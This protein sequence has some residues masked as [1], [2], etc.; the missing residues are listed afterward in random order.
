MAVPRLLLEILEDLIEDDF[1]E[2]KWLLENGV[3][4]KPIARSH[5]ENAKRRDTVRKMIDTYRE[6]MAV[7]IAVG[8]LKEMGNNN[9]AEK[10]K[11]SYAAGGNTATPSTSTSAAA[12]PAAPAAPASM[13][14]Q[15]GSI[16]IAPNVTGGTSGTWNININK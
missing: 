3:D 4:F 10:L 11:N 6:E 2:F 9:A 7:K 8:V 12:P 1:N 14:A 16:I 5:L 13:T 15:Q